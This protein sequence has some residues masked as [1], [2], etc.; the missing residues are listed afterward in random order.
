M[1]SFLQITPDKLN[2]IVGPRAQT[3]IDVRCQQ[4]LKLSR[5]VFTYRLSF[6]LHP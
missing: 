6:E 4:E 3:L 5:G 2:R 1:P